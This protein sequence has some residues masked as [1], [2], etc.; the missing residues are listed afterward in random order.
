MD[1]LRMHLLSQVKT[2]RWAFD[3]WQEYIERASEKYG[4]AQFRSQGEKWLRH[5]LGCYVSWL[6]FM[7][8]AETPR[9]DDFREEK[10]DLFERLDAFVSKVELEEVFQSSDGT[11]GWTATT[12]IQ[13]MLT[14]G[15]YHRGQLRQLAEAAGLTDWPE[16]DYFRNNPAEI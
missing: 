10:D 2:E 4:G 11:R 14:H 9:A 3:L 13:H 12:L 16:T 8:K 6:D 5:T 7:E 15:A 1:S